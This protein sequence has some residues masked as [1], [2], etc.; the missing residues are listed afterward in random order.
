MFHHWLEADHGSECDDLFTGSHGQDFRG[1]CDSPPWSRRYSRLCL[2]ILNFPNSIG[3]L[4]N[5]PGLWCYPYLLS[6]VRPEERPI[7][8]L[9]TWHSLLWCLLCQWPSSPN[10][11]PRVFSTA[12]F[13]QPEVIHLAHVLFRPWTM[14]H[15]EC[16]VSLDMWALHSLEGEARIFSYMLV[17]KESVERHFDL[18]K[19]NSLL[20]FTSRLWSCCSFSTVPFPLCLILR[21][22]EFA[23]YNQQQQQQKR[24]LGIN[25]CF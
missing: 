20:C 11:L 15:S 22:Q 21:H 10:Q 12:Q 23:D 4:H 14:F 17:E 18:S 13:L 25:M 8:K 2:S 1:H 19:E 5:R 16:F 3:T 9:S 7:W 24:Y 6:R